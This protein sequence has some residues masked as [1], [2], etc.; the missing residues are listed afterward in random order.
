MAGPFGAR[1]SNGL[2]LVADGGMGSLL[3]AAVPRLRTPEEA[4][5]GAPGAV[6]SLHVSFI[7][8]GAELIETNTSGANRRKLAA[9]YLDDEL[10]RINTT[11]VNL[12][13]DARQLTGRDVFI[14][15]SM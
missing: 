14:G 13:R 2:P 3:T 4:N 12:A 10:E 11:G 5:L 6:V 9:H 7:E 15:G 1:L 8:A